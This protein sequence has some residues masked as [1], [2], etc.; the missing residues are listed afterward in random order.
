[1]P[2]L[3]CR[4]SHVCAG[5]HARDSCLRHEE[6]T[7]TLFYARSILIV[8]TSEM[9]ILFIIHVSLI[10]VFDA[11]MLYVGQYISRRSYPV[12]FFYKQT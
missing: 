6:N 12:K 4:F 8:C 10:Q 9:H 3:G 2:V 7:G 1:M 5:A 11:H